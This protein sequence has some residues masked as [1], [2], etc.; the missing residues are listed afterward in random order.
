VVSP[1]G[2]RLPRWKGSGWPDAL[3]TAYTSGNAVSRREWR[4]LVDNILVDNNGD[5]RGEEV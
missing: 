1:C 2:R 3:D 4:V 5:G